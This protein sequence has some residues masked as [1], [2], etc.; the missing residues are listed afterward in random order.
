M[1]LPGRTQCQAAITVQ[2]VSEN[3]LEGQKER[4]DGIKSYIK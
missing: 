1:V 3:D 2:R 4:R